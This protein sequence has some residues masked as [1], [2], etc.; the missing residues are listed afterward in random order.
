[1]PRA[2]EFNLHPL[3]WEDGP[4]EERFKLCALDYLSTITYTNSVIFFKLHDTDKR[5][6]PVQVP[7]LTERKVTDIS[8]VKP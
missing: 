6:D 3:G 2:E 5:L 7:L 1:M 4:D 8:S